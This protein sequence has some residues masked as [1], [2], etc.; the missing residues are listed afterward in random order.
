MFG[1][2]KRLTNR[3]E[4]GVLTGKPCSMA[5]RALAKKRQVVERS[6]FVRRMLASKE[7]TFRKACVGFWFGQRCNLYNGKSKRVR[8]G[9]LSLAPIR[10]LCR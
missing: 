6:Y 10:R 5:V 2:Y 1:Q 3:F 7:W 9:R 8:R 4:A